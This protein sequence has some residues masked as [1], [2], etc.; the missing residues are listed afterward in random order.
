MEVFFERKYKLKFML[1][2][3]FHRLVSFDINLNIFFASKEI[4]SVKKSLS[5]YI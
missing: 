5:N 1:K 4:P 2:I 3:K